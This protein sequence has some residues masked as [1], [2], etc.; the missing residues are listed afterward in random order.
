MAIR[1]TQAPETTTES[2]LIQSVSIETQEYETNEG[3]APDFPPTLDGADHLI[4]TSTDYQ[5]FGVPCWGG[6]YID[7][8]DTEASHAYEP[9]TPTLADGTAWLPVPHESE[10]CSSSAL[11]TPTDLSP[12]NDT[13][14][15]WDPY[16]FSTLAIADEFA[17]LQG[18]CGG[19]YGSSAQSKPDR[20]AL[21]ANIHTFSRALQS[22]PTQG[23]NSEGATGLNQ[24]E[25]EPLKATEI[26]IT[27]AVTACKS[28]EGRLET[29]LQGALVGSSWFDNELSYALRCSTRS[30]AQAGFTLSC[31]EGSETFKID[32]ESAT[33]N[34]N[35][36]GLRA[37]RQ[38]A[39]R[40]QTAADLD[41][42]NAID[43]ERI[44]DQTV[45]QLQVPT[46]PEKKRR[47]RGSR[48]TCVNRKD[49]D[50][51]LGRPRRRGPLSDAARANARLRRR[52]K[53]TCINCR[54]TKRACDG[55]APCEACGIPLV[56]QPCIRA[57]FANIVESGTCNYISQRAVHY[58]T[59]DESGPV[60]IE[61]PPELEVK[62]VL[63]ELHARQRRFNVRVIGGSE[64]FFII[65]ASHI[66]A[67]LTGITQSTAHSRLDFFT[68]IDH[69]IPGQ[70]SGPEDWRSCITTD[71]PVENLN[72]LLWKWN[73]MPSRFRYSLI[74]VSDKQPERELTIDIG[75]D[76]PDILLAAQLSRIIRRMVEVEGFRRLERKLYNI[77][78]KQMTHE[79]QL[80]FLSDLGRIL[81]TLRWR[82][83][84]WK[85]FGDGGSKSRSSMQP[86]TDR[87]TMLS[88][89][90]YAYYSSLRSRLPSWLK[91]T[92]TGIWSRNTHCKSKVWNDFP[93]D[94]SDK[95]FAAW[96]DHG[97]ELTSKADV[98]CPVAF[99]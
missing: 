88:R 84:W 67:F 82:L 9:W 65:N 99:L 60:R 97:E 89:I 72:P 92:P 6:A 35:A 86:Y 71:A 62:D 80:S 90:L 78:W 42:P 43:L 32:A 59:N 95:G 48:T 91:E 41:L 77:K 70:M 8:G 83:S 81:F 46:A 39:L 20:L 29:G 56:D 26:A 1:H 37:E 3:G 44:L 76:Q 17:A 93:N 2:M 52:N 15:H 66:E 12:G 18:F 28:D 94:P 54:L 25:A 61:I 79:N 50:S 36:T 22:Y 63:H 16:D 23:S 64:P 4:L 38:D 19:P 98:M 34:K 55:D 57:C 75:Q 10:D 33:S 27:T 96:I 21:N 87:V 85:L 13:W 73:H 7:L 31:T 14:R 24:D 30:S 49:V 47:T 11:I 45:H 40:R 68:F 51:S 69:I 5:P 58:P 53:D 74:P